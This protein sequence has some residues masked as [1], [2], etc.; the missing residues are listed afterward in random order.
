MSSPRALSARTRSS[1]WLAWAISFS[2]SASISSW[3]TKPNCSSRAAR[4]LGPGKSSE[5]SPA[6]RFREM[7]STSAGLPP[8][9]TARSQASRSASSARRWAASISAGVGSPSSW[10][11]MTP[12]QPG[13]Y[14]PSP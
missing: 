14:G 6:L 7:P 9:G 3:D 2:M 13:R 8:R 10:E 5:M 12:M 11:K 1:A 4:R